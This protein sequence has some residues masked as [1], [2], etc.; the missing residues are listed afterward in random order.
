VLAVRVFQTVTTA[1]PVLDRGAITFADVPWRAPTCAEVCCTFCR[2][3]VLTISPRATRLLDMKT[4]KRPTVYIGQCKPATAKVGHNLHITQ[5]RE[6]AQAAIDGHIARI[7]C[8][9][10]HAVITL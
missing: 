3:G 6:N 1:V 10:E 2:I 7:G 4:N 9:H 8:T 5:I